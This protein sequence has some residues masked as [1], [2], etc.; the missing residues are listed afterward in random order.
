MARVPPVGEGMDENLTYSADAHQD[1]D[2]KTLIKAAYPMT[3]WLRNCTS[4]TT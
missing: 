2:C 4:R 1:N 3:L